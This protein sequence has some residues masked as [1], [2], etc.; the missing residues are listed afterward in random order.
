MLSSGMR[1]H[2]IWLKFTDVSEERTASI[3]RTEE[4]AKQVTSRTQAASKAGQ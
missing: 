3:F 4:Y 2:T 1:L